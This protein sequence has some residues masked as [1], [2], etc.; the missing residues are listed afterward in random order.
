MSRLFFAISILCVSLI[1][2]PAL[3]ALNETASG[4]PNILWLTCEDISPH[5]GCYGDPYA[6][7]PN[8]DRL[9]AGGVRYTNA[10]AVNG[11]CAPSRSCLITGVYPWS[12]GSQH[13]RSS[14]RLPEVVKCFTEYLRTAGYYCSNNSKEDYNCHAPQ[15]AWD[16]SSGKAHWRDRAP[17]QPFFSVFNYTGTHESRLF[18]H[19]SGAKLPPERRHD[20]AEANIPPYHPD[21]PIGRADWAE[22]ANTVTLLDDWVAQRLDELKQAGLAEDTIVF[23]FAD[24][25]VGLPRGKY[26]LYDS[27][28]HVPLI[29]HFSKKYRHL[30][31][32][33]PDSVVEQPVDFSDFGPTVLSLAGV[34]VPPHMQGR[35]FL[36]PQQAEPREYVFVGR[37]RAG[38]Y[39]TD[40]IRGVRDRRYK[41]LRNNMIYRPYNRITWYT[42]RQNSLRELYRLADES[43]LPEAAAL[44]MGHRP[45]PAEE[46][47]DLAN[48]PHELHNLA[49]SAEHRAIVQQKR[50]VLRKHRI[51]VLDLGL[52]PEREMHARVPDAAPYDAARQDP[53][54]FPL[55]RILG[56]LDLYDRGPDAAPELRALTAADDA[57]LRYWAVIGLANLADDTPETLAALRP[58]LDDESVDVQLAAVEALCELGRHAETLPALAAALKHPDNWVQLRTLTLIDQMKEKALPLLADV[59]H[60]KGNTQLVQHIVHS[61]QSKPPDRNR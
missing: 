40:A 27:G 13:M 54:P 32:G 35:A 29:V 5:L 59:Q 48:D 24:H 61:M 55:E 30:A 47:Y 31:P 25:G 16:E 17:G 53:S 23:F 38:T 14:V 34:P 36:G 46:L 12:L 45:R 37:D 28:V 44:F 15:E 9:A 41:Y 43:K 8:L 60:V 52:L 2:S 51:E 19:N 22:Y 20:P 57:A 58:R 21:T 18:V 3:A 50:R 49:E 56:V 33:G 10:F 26:L 39:G 42:G 6:T 11:Q 4:Q 1:T 7:T